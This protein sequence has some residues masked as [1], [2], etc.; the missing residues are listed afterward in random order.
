M[1]KTH[2][3]IA[4]VLVS[5]LVLLTVAA[6]A[7]TGYDSSED[8]II[9]L[10]YL[11]DIFKPEFRSEILKVVDEKISAA[12]KSSDANPAASVP[13]S[14][15]EPVNAGSDHPAESSSSEFEVVAMKS[16]DELYASAACEIML[17]SGT[18]IAIAPDASQGLADYTSGEEIYAGQSL[19][20]NH[21]CLI[22][23]GDGRGILATSD[24]VYIMVRGEYS[25]YEGN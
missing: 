15:N 24:N 22:P 5:C 3:V 12:L 20:K 8:P 11:T 2:I 13:V 25:Y 19:V 17:R 4:A 9:S 7:A 16:G 18:A 6:Y 21:M 14:N 10:S 23:R 1:K